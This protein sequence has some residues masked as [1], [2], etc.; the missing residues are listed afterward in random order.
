MSLQ[1][2][3]SHCMKLRTREYQALV[4]VLGTRGLETLV[5]PSHRN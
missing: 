3:L 2:L 5:V 1:L 4:L